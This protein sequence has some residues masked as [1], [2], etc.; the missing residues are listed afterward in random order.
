[1]NEYILML[2]A[3]LEDCFSLQSDAV[4]DWKMEGFDQARLEALRP[5]SPKPEESAENCFN[6]QAGLADLR[7]FTLETHYCNFAFW[8]LLQTGPKERASAETRAFAQDLLKSRAYLLPRTDNALLALL[9]PHLP[10]GGRGTINTESPARAIDRMSM[11]SIKLAHFTNLPTVTRLSKTRQE[12][13]ATLTKRLRQER[14]LLAEAILRLVDEYAE[15]E[16]R[17]PPARLPEP[18]LELAS[19]LAP[20]LAGPAEE[21]YHMAAGLACLL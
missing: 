4:R 9:T 15:G 21:L 13:C 16:K 14:Q 3:G 1:M 7:A 10:E 12:Q 6:W 2:K 5:R 19:E 11:L 20:E 17:L 18:S 8:Q